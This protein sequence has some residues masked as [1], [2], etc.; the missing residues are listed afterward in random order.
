MAYLDDAGFNSLSWMDKIRYVTGDPERLASEKKR[1]EGVFS[2]TGSAEAQNYL[3]QLNAAG[4]GVN[5]DNVI[6]GNYD[7]NKYAW[8]PPD[9]SQY[10]TGVRSTLKQYGISDDA[11]GWADD[12]KGL[13]TVTLGGQ[14]A[15]SPDRV[16]NGVSYVDDAAKVRDAALG[17]YKSQGKNIVKLAD[18]AQNSGLP[19]SVNYNNGIVSVGG[20]TI[21]PVFEDDGYAYVDAAEL[22]KVL[23]AAKQQAG[24]QTGNEIVDKYNE[25]YGGYYDKLIESMVNRKPY[26]YDPENDPAFQ[27]YREQYNREGDRAMRD[28][29]GAMAGQT[30]GYTNSAAV[31]A[32]AQ[33]RQYWQDKLMDRIPEL[34]ANAYNRYLG[35]FDLD[36]NAL[37]AVMGLDNNQFTR[38]YGVSRDLRGDLLDNAD[39]NQA[40]YD[41][42]YEKWLTER[43][44]KDSR[45][46]LEYQKQYTKDRDQVA[47][48]QWKQTFDRGVIESDR[49]FALDERAADFDYEDQQILRTIEAGQ[50]TGYYSP[51]QNAFLAKVWGYPEGTTFDP[52]GKESNTAKRQY[53]LEQTYGTRGGSGGS[54]SSKSGSKASGSPLTFASYPTLSSNKHVGKEVDFAVPIGTPVECPVSG[55]VV[56]IQSRT[57]SYGKNVRVR[58]ADGNTHYFAH[59]SEFGDIQ[60][61][62]TINAG[63]LIGYS[64]DTG[65]GGAHLH[66]EVRRGDD[67]YDQLDPYRYINAYNNSVTASDN[68]KDQQKNNEERVK[69]ALDK[70]VEEYG[71]G[72]IYDLPDAVI[73]SVI[74]SSLS[75]KSEHSRIMSMYNIPQNIL[76]KDILYTP[77]ETVKK[78]NAEVGRVMAKNPGNPEVARRLIQQWQDSGAISAEVADALMDANGLL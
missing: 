10:G 48:D 53:E 72:G 52:F 64:G 5:P 12:G 7:K 34:E 61:G 43:A 75:N 55:T 38:E 56:K 17:Y 6:S 62:D 59:L 28:A 65:N 24:Y 18:Y 60:E 45:D 57:D 71:L 74:V 58:D 77:N 66:Y 54:G 76:E 8:R 44:Y 1:A 70:K 42:E 11:I 33:Q 50:T 22:D 9:D 21:K 13:G 63:D 15:L 35:E 67:Q 32:G 20:Q 25:K 30:G 16:V 78:Y 41:R 2:S 4:S 49:A 23:A 68:L 14:A 37:D 51:E 3:G 19:F 46:D 26:S 69:A 39:R 73:A 29:M 47:D 36:R 27:S 31:T 40:R